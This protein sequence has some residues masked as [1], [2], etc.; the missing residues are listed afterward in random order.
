MTTKCPFCERHKG[1]TDAAKGGCAA[2]GKQEAYKGVQDLTSGAETAICDGDLRTEP[3]LLCDGN[4]NDS[5][6]TYPE[7]SEL[8]GRRG[9]GGS[10]T[11]CGHDCRCFSADFLHESG[12]WRLET[13]K[14]SH[15]PGSA[16][17]EVPGE[18]V[19]WSESASL[20]G[21][22]DTLWD[23]V[24]GLICRVL[25]HSKLGRPGGLVGSPDCPIV[26]KLN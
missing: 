19:S 24:W 26:E 3:S 18:E 15:Q 14:L 11:T 23:S 20:L 13:H 9:R 10:G 12:S 22:S 4:V 2:A 1:W 25:F 16:V 6:D 17:L 7:K 21:S 5:A 8:S